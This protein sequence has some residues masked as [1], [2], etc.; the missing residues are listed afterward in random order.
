[1]P[2]EAFQRFPN[3]S[4]WE[5]ACYNGILRR[6][7]SLSTLFHPAGCVNLYLFTIPLITSVLAIDMGLKYVLTPSATRVGVKKSPFYL[8]LD[9]SK[10]FYETSTAAVV[11]VPAFGLSAYGSSGGGE[12]GLDNG[13][14]WEGRQ[15]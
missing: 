2:H 8:L 4:V 1:M 3:Y 14:S 9:G 6:Y 5:Q 13:Y 7:L 11:C 10:S 12:L 15:P